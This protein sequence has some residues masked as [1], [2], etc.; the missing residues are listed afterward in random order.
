[1]TISIH[2]PSIHQRAGLVTPI[3]SV[4]FQSIHRDLCT[5]PAG[6]ACN[7]SGDLEWSS[8]AEDT[9]LDKNLISTLLTS[10]LLLAV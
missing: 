5:L 1:V 3:P 8:A 6:F 9:E 2:L 10:R 4:R 7:S